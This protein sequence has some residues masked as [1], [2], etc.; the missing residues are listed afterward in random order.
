VRY[1]DL[2][3]YIGGHWKKAPG[4]PELNPVDES[5]LG[6][7]PGVTRSDL[8]AALAAAGDG[9]KKWSKTPPSRRYEIILKA[10]ALMRCD[11]T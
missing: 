11:D 10:V 1:P 9:F 5:V 7:I 6:T 8:D 3:L 4:Q 2:E